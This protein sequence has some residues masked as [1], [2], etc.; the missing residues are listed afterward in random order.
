MRGNFTISTN[1]IKLIK[2]L[3]FVPIEKSIQIVYD[4]EWYDAVNQF[5]LYV[6]NP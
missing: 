2:R 6:F 3:V 4:S 1:I 5:I